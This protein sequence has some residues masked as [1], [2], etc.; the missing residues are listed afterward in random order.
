MVQ[1]I[2]TRIYTSPMSSVLKRG[3]TWRAFVCVDNKR[4]SKS[5][6]TKREA[7]AWAHEQEKSGIL[8]HHTFREALERY[9][10]ISE[11]KK[12]YQAELS[13]LDSLH[14]VKFI[15][16]PLEFITSAMIAEYRDNRLREVA[17]VSVRRE[18]III[19]AMFTKAIREWG[20][21]TDHPI[22]L[23]ERPQTS[24]PRKRGITQ[25][26]IDTI[27]TKLL[28]ARV[29][30]QVRDMFL[31]SIE[32]AMRLGEVCGMKWSDVSEK[33]VTLE[34]TKN[35]DKRN[36]P[37]S[38]KAREIINSRRGIDEEKVFILTRYV[39]SQTFR[40][41][42]IND[43]HFHDARSEAITR[44]SKKLDVMQLARAIGHRDLK[45]LLIYYAESPEDIADR[46]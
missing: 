15:D 44:L 41:A 32:T 38:L 16:T 22:K 27:S 12:G 5:F 46:L 35:G 2:Y 1:I 10:P 39:T 42:S 36:V 45:S 21:M 30:V 11:A 25:D 13:R 7:T 26:E 23:V 18:M 40:R 28:K 8:A 20:W 34:D 3:E 14:A 33:T 24:K 4:R 19:G 31:F 29:G 6:A 37:L 43:V 9:R 17:P